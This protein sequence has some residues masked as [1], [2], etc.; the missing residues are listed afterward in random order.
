MDRV[1]QQWDEGQG[2]ALALAVQPGGWA[3]L[4][5]LAVGDLILAVDGR[6]VPDVKSLEERMKS[7]A[8]E[9][10]RHVTLFVRRGIHTVFVEMEPAW[11]AP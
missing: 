3:A 2:G 6:A 1:T 9:K 7:I 8:Q 10:P 5:H 4:A 11:P